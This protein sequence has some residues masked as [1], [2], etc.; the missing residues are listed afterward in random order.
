MR[1]CFLCGKVES[2]YCRIEVHHIFPGGNRKK[3]DKLGLVVDLCHECHNE[4]PNGAHF[5]KHTMLR[6]KQYGQRKAMTEQ[7]WSI[8]DFIREFGKNYLEDD[9]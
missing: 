4:P 7:G 8:E 2:S 1:E 5:N 3:S 9:E 6:L